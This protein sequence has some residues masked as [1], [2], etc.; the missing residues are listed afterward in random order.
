M[1]TETDNRVNTGADIKATPWYQ[2]KALLVV[3]V[4]A[5]AIFFR[6][7]YLSVSQQKNL[8]PDLF[9]DSKYY[10]KVAVQIHNGYGAGEHPYLLSP[11][12]PYLLAPFVTEENVVD[13]HRVR[14]IQ[15]LFGALTCVLVALIATTVLNRYAGWLAGL[16][17][18]SF[19]PLIH[20][21]QAILVASLQVFTMTLCL[22]CLIQQRVSSIRFKYNV[23]A[24]FA[25]GVSTAL[26]PTGLLLII[27]CA[28]IFCLL[29]WRYRD[30]KILQ[31]GLLPFVL[32]A[33]VVI[34]PFT[35]HNIQAGGEPILLSANGGMNFWIG[36]HQGSH[37]VFN[38]PPE[39]D[40][41]HD[42]LGVDYARKRSG[43]ML[44]YQQSSS[45]WREQAMTDIA[46]DP[47]RWIGL[48]G[49]KALL[50]SHHHEI[51]QLGLNFQW[52]QQKA[53]P[54]QVFPVNSLQLILL[55]L[56]APFFFYIRSHG[57]N[58]AEQVV[59]RVGWPMLFLFVYWGA[60]A[61]FFVT[62]RYRA[63]I[64]P[65]VIVLAACT[66]VMFLELLV[67]KR[68]NL[69]LVLAPAFL[70]FVL[71][72]VGN[73]LY[74]SNYLLPPVNLYSGTEERQQGMALYKQGK[75][76]EAEMS[77]R[78]SLSIRENSITRGNLA[79]ALKA[80]GRIDEAEQEYLKVLKANPKDAVVI[81]NLANLYRDHKN[82]PLRAIEFYARA[83]Q[84]RPRFAEA[85]LNRGLLQARLGRLE[86][87][88]ESLQLYLEHA[89]VDAKNREAVTQMIVKISLQLNQ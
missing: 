87:A 77:Y 2:H 83:T 30:K 75:F 53:W 49:K 40:L 33:G 68:E 84:I 64:M 82:D 47:V 89:P 56:F 57:A 16:T 76:R 20:Y 74:A 61:L 86:E 72:V 59:G 4:F 8:F 51:P 44:N 63:P 31:Q 73:R 22:W 78:R 42:P 3:A 10:Q 24:G 35:L 18:A 80:Q 1:D 32:A 70:F 67:R 28:V 41:V 46:N 21:D 79:N 19:G 50:F 45:W 36:N 62:G 54:L 17:C 43:E 55:A 38:L 85:H 66:V 52:Y 9:L 13:A 60:I 26:R 11:L 34:S 69:T 58:R 88:G 27:A 14:I 71:N 5:V 7:S 65:G 12:Y 23:L 81:Y 29:Y 25:L 6:F 37:G 39:Y 48:L 15:S